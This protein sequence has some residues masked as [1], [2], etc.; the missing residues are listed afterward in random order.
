[1]AVE[2][3]ALL[4]LERTF[5]ESSEV[6]AIKKKV[7]EFVAEQ[8]ACQPD[9]IDEDT[10]LY[11][12]LRVEGDDAWDLFLDFSKEFHFPP[13]EIDVEGCFPDEPHMCNFF[14]FFFFRPKRRV[15]IKHL[16]DAVMSKKWPQLEE[17]NRTRI[18]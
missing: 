13:D 3:K 16:I 11:R 10:D 14:S 17:V 15:R 8:A 9:E 6:I 12:D 1:M 4:I 2:P 5:M 18:N 7:I